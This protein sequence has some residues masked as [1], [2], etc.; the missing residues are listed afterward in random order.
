MS[1]KVRKAWN[2]Q[3]ISKIERVAC[4]VFLSLPYK[5]VKFIRIKGGFGVVCESENSWIVLLLRRSDYPFFQFVGKKIAKNDWLSLQELYM[6]G[7]IVGIS[8]S[9]KFTYPCKK[10]HLTRRLNKFLLLLKDN[11][12][13]EKVKGK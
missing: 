9:T 8:G 4:E 7:D 2:W 11:T 13:N 6:L 10:I 5:V 12:K 1:G 3:D